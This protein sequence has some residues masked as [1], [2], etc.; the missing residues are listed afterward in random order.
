MNLVVVF[1][2]KIGE[3][4]IVPES[5]IY[6]LDMKQLK[7]RGKNS[8]RDYLV[9]WADDIIECEFYP[10]PNKD[11]VVMYSFPAGRGGW[12]TG[13]T[14]YFSGDILYKSTYK[15]FFISTDF[16]LNLDDV[17]E[18]KEIKEKRRNFAPPVYNPARLNEKPVP[19]LVLVSN[20][21]LASE[22]STPDEEDPL[23]VSLENETETNDLEVKIIVYSIFFCSFKTNKSVLLA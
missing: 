4:F 12:F 3:H 21:D 2:T 1:L 5:Y 6:D 16:V 20:A 13:R 11:A 19:K 23:N 14:V 7:N 8:C 9:Y 10:E 15:G 17:Q 18:A 22:T